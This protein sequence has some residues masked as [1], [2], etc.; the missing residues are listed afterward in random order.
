MFTLFGL[1]VT[2]LDVIALVSL[3]KSG[4]DTA[5]KILWALLIV[6]LPLLGM[7]LYFLMGPGR[8]KII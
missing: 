7:V 2:V 5:T 1:L 4:A 3:L 8:R 6:L